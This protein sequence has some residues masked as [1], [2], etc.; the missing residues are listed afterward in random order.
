MIMFH[1]YHCLNHSIVRCRIILQSFIHCH[2]WTQVEFDGYEKLESYDKIQWPIENHEI[3]LTWLPSCTKG[4]L[5]PLPGICTQRKTFLLYKNHPLAASH[6]FRT[7]TVHNSACANVECSRVSWSIHKMF[8]RHNC[9][10]KLSLHSTINTK[11]S[12][13][14]MS[15]ASNTNESQR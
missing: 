14:F 5:L 1:A 12:I 9:L 15:N 4:L 8:V 11:Q 3:H 7:Y 10:S 6:Y 2:T 13:Y